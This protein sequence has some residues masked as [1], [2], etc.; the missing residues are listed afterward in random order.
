M[1]RVSRLWD[2]RGHAGRGEYWA[3]SVVG[4][5]VVLLSNLMVSADQ[6]RTLAVSLLPILVLILVVSVHGAV[7][8]RR[9]HDR[10]RTAWWAVLF[11][12]AP[13]ILG[14]FSSLAGPAASWSPGL[15]VAFVVLMAVIAW[16][17]VELAILDGKR[18]RNP[19]LS[20][21]VRDVSVFD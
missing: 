19:Y 21:T 14:G 1:E 8:A 7:T 20:P 6:G 16:A 17:F 13:L 5:M 18:S 15:I 2:F 4:N 3:I 9:L 11:V 12:G 10:G